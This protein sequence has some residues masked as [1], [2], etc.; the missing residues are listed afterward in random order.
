MPSASLQGWQSRRAR[1]LDEIEAA[2]AAVGGCGRGRRWATEQINHAYVV[3]VSS[4]FQGFCRD[5]HSESVDLLART[6][7]PASLRNVLRAEFVF[8]RSL[9]R[10]NA[11]PANI[12]SDFKRLGVAFWPQVETH[13]RRNSNRRRSLENLSRWRNAIAHQD[14]GPSRL[15]PA[16]LGLGTVRSWRGACDG[17]ARSF[18]RV[19]NRYL[20]SVLG[21]APW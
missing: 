10:G 7:S 18:D 17:L 1:E 15:T 12:E 20:A 9:D 16:R 2:H 11:N 4:Q 21:T 3:L 13:D 14:F 8:G 6:I 5:L 19:L